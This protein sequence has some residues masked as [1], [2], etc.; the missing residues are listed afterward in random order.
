MGS[1]CQLLES[2]AQA[3]PLREWIHS[4]RGDVLCIWPRACQS[5]CITWRPSPTTTPTLCEGM[6]TKGDRNTFCS[7]SLSHAVPGPYCQVVALDQISQS[8][9]RV[10]LV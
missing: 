1:K 10:G 5:G 8:L 6:M 2:T 3:L 7:F 4:S 9:L